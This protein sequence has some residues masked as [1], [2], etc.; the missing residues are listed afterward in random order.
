MCNKREY[1]LNEFLRN[2]SAVW[3]F[4]WLSSHDYLLTRLGIQNGILVSPLPM[5]SQAVEKLLKSYLCFQ[6][7]EANNNINVMKQE[8]RKFCKK[9]SIS[10]SKIDEHDVDLLLKFAHDEYGLLVPQEIKELMPNIKMFLTSVIQIP[11]N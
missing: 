7:S 4:A 11:K 2:N 10:R 3:K 8:F 9:L 1:L 5:F 6:V